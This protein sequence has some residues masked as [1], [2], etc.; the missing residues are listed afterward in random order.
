MEENLQD[1]VTGLALE[2]STVR[3]QWAKESISTHRA[4]IGGK[5]RKAGTGRL[6]L[7]VKKSPDLP[8]YV[9]TVCGCGTRSLDIS[10][11]SDRTH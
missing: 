1:R 7:G 11:S 5:T 10:S 9:H 8:A 3:A 2:C 4:G 6:G